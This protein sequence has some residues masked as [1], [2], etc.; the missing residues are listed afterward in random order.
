[1]S[2]IS[3]VPTVPSAERRIP[4]AS[5]MPSHEERSRAAPG[6]WRMHQL[7]TRVLG[8]HLA[9]DIVLELFAQDEIRHVPNAWR[10][11]ATHRNDVLFQGPPEVRAT[12]SEL[13]HRFGAYV[14]AGRI[15][16]QTARSICAA[17]RSAWRALARRDNFT[18]MLAPVL[19][20]FRQR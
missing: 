3:Q 13:T 1:M 4:S 14:F 8:A 20:V 19:S 2:L 11:V 5:K 12:R 17:I 9:Q 18:A 6:R 10:R 7:A 15:R 16:S